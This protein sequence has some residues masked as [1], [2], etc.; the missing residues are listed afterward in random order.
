MK[1]TLAPPIPRPAFPNEKRYHQPSHSRHGKLAKIPGEPVGSGEALQ[2]AAAGGPCG[3]SQQAHAP[4]P[5]TWL[6]CPSPPPSHAET[7][8]CVWKPCLCLCFLTDLLHLAHK[9]GRVVECTG[10]EE[11]FSLSL[12]G[13]RGSAPGAV[14]EARTGAGY[15]SQQCTTRDWQ[16]VRTRRDL[17]HQSP[18]N[19]NTES[20][21]VTVL[22]FYT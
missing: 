4:N 15:A 3:C 8:A 12:E 21:L 11:S 2:E 20:G 10:K 18:K 7:P 5:C 22:A 1:S 19:I 6:P 13:G 9:R 16:Q 17:C 14:R